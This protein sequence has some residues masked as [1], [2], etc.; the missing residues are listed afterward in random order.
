MEDYSA[1]KLAVDNANRSEVSRRTG[2][3]LS[4]ISRIL[5]GQ[6]N[7]RSGN[8]LAIAQ[9]LGLKMDDLYSWLKFIKA[10][11]RKRRGKAQVA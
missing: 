2:I 8:L 4:G 3:S 6:R 11:N 10:K 9:V 5:S 7:P 1:V